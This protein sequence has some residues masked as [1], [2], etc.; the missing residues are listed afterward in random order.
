MVRVRWRRES[1]ML[2]DEVLTISSTQSG[3]YICEQ[4]VIRSTDRRKPQLSQFPNSWSCVTSFR[5]FETFVRV[6][7]KKKAWN[8]KVMENLGIHY[9]TNSFIRLL[10]IL[11]QQ[12]KTF[13]DP[14]IDE[15]ASLRPRRHRQS[16]VTSSAWRYS[17]INLACS[18]SVKQVWLETE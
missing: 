5:Y 16:N 14:S 18:G 1:L 12:P 6:R 7:K 4:G 13:I 2:N 10:T 9:P 15:A 17:N 11:S 3:Q 8:K